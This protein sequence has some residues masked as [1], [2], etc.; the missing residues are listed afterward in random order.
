MTK[1]RSLAL[2]DMRPTLWM[3]A[4]LMAALLVSA[5]SGGIRADKIAFDGVNFR[6]SASAIDKQRDFFEV[7]VAPA[8]SSILGA[9]E[10]G[11]Y[12]ATRYCIKN[13]GSSDMDWAQGPDA[14]DGTLIID[15]DRLILRGTCTP[16]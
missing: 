1:I 14:A 12:E 16:Q 3:G 13:F 11:R 7:T 15:N 9:R 4:L 2:T 8:S 6:S 10:A 5:C